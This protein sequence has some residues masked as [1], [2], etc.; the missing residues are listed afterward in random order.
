MKLITSFEEACEKKGY[1][2]VKIL[3]D[4]SAYPA[5]HQ[6]A[7]IAT[8]K[9]FIV[10]EVLNTDDQGN[11][12]EIDWND[13]NV[14]KHYPWF[15]LETYEEDSSPGFR[16]NDTSFDDTLSDV[17]SRLCY[18]TRALAKHAGEHFIDLYKDLMII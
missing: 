11:I 3:P 8:A 13:C 4:V 15:D 12:W 1:D 18:R 17:G 7:I 14:E 2:P 10:N 6:K 9:L 5:Q 16:F